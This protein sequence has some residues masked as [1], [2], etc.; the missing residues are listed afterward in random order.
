MKLFIAFF[1]LIQHFSKYSL[2]RT[3]PMHQHAIQVLLLEFWCNYSR[4]FLSKL[5]D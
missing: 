5:F 2:I 3:F 4:L 1:A